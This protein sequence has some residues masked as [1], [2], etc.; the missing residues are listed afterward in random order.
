ML[1]HRVR[2]PVFPITILLTLV[3]LTAA[4]TTGASGPTPSTTPT[5]TPNQ[6]RNE[7]QYA[8]EELARKIVSLIPKDAIG[9]ILEP[10]FASPIT[11]ETQMR[12]GE[13]VIGVSINGDARAYPINMLSEHEIVN[14]VVGEKPIAVTW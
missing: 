11:A 14:D 3:L 10:K 1:S 7:A 5:P 8:V 9:A 4:C 2:F 6:S 12:D 13:L